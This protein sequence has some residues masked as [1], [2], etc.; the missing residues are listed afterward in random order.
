VSRSAIASGISVDDA[1]ALVRVEV[2]PEALEAR[3]DALEHSRHR[4]ARRLGEPH[5]VVPAVPV[6]GW[7]F[8]PARRLDRLPELV[9]LAA[10]VVV[11]VLALDRVARKREEPCYAVAVG[12]VPGRCDRDRACWVRR[13]HLDLNTLA[14]GGRITPEAVAVLEDAGERFSEPCVLQ[15]EIDESRT[16][17]GSSGHVVER[18][19]SVRELR[20]DLAGRPAESAGELQRNV[21][22]IVAMRRI[23]RS[24]EVDGSSGRVAD[25]PCELLDG[26]RH[27]LKLQ[28]RTSPP[29]GG[30]DRP[31]PPRSARRRHRALNPARAP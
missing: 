25:R 8:T 6:L 3:L 16:G 9:H 12:T 18:A 30:S 21:G 24:L 20:R 27:G 23:P 22:R 29:G 10:G 5:D 14:C 15:L 2:D 13:H 28:G 4:V 7:F 11:V 26:I 19:S 31:T 17:N 1:L